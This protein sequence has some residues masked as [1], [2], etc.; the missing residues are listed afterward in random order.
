MVQLR[1]A[2]SPIAAQFILNYPGCNVSEVSKDWST[3]C[4]RTIKATFLMQKKLAIARE[5]TEVMGKAINAVVVSLRQTNVSEEHP[6]ESVCRS[7]EKEF[8]KDSNLSVL[9]EKVKEVT[10]G[11]LKVVENKDEFPPI[12]LSELVE[13]LRREPE[14]SRRI[15]LEFIMDVASYGDRLYNV[16]PDLSVEC[17]KTIKAAALLEAT[18]AITVEA[19]E[20]IEDTFTAVVHDLK[21]ATDLKEHPLEVYCSRIEKAFA[22][23]SNLSAS[24]EKAKKKAANLKSAS[25]HPPYSRVILKSDLLLI[26][27]L[28]DSLAV[29]EFSNVVA[30]DSFTSLLKGKETLPMRAFIFAK[31]CQAVARKD[32]FADSMQNIY[33]NTMRDFTPEITAND[34]LMKLLESLDKGVMWWVPKMLKIFYGYV[35]NDAFLRKEVDSMAASMFP[36]ASK[37]DLDFAKL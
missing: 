32:Q 7:I 6:L 36:S 2:W 37:E 28:I 5:V 18:L 22:A 12:P 11:L 15:H 27:Q 9:F 35:A 30:F 16:Y 25:R 34:R 19:S 8:A 17:S 13:E 24:F 29:P 3:D 4:S 14:N 10:N 21:N 1:S 33:E 26:N 23:N 31:S 20:V